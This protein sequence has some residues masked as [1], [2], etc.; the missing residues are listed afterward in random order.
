MRVCVISSTLQSHWFILTMKK[1][2]KMD[3]STII[4]LV[5]WKDKILSKMQGLNASFAV[6]DPTVNI[7]LLKGRNS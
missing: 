4:S 1:L 7:Q 5:I 2:M 3:V 6:L